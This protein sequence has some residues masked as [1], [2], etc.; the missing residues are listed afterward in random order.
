MSNTAELDLMDIKQA[1]EWASRYLGKN[2]T[3]S[4]ITYLLQYGRIKKIGN[5]GNTVINKK[6]LINYYKSFNGKREINWKNQLGS[7]L[8]WALS[9]DNVKEAETTK[10]VHRLHPYKG[11]FIPQLV[12]Y[13][14]DSHKDNFKKE[15]YFKKGDIM[16][17]PFCGSG[18]AL[19]QAN[20]LGMHAIGIDISVFNSLISNIKIDSYD[21]I[22]L[23]NELK[24]ITCKLKNFLADSETVKFE[25]ALLVELAKFNNKFFPAPEFRYK[26]SR[27]QINEYKY[28][29]EKEKEFLPIFLRLVKDYKIQLKQDKS[30]TFLDKWYLQHIRNEINFVAGLLKQ[31]KNQKIKGLVSVIL[32]RTIR[33]CRATTHSDLATLKEPVTQTYYCSK[34][35]KICK[36]LFSILSWWE[37]YSI[38]TIE[39][40]EFFKKLRTDT[41]QICL[42]GDARAINIFEEM[43]ETDPE[44]AKILKKQKIRGI[45]SSPPYVGLID[46]HEQHAYAYDLFGLKRR[47]E[48]EIGPLSKGQ[49]NEARLSYVQ[50][51]AEVL[52]NCKKFLAEDYN[53][54]LVAN[55]KYN[56]YPQIA[57]EANMK[58]VNRHRRPVLNRTERD[59]SA[60]SE[61]I[62]HLK[63]K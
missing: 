63:E 49:G 31:I 47:D 48:L 35:G 46:Y 3:T 1:S 60:Y 23:H 40:I 22:Q 26:V 11:K 42:T 13:F 36:P 51:I 52:K 53:I 20:E 33:S 38:D 17:D 32:S 10:H 18:T 39:R 14:L 24:N 7:D 55:D 41:Y 2:V 37:R 27:G 43:D 19:V 12:E 6:E 44:F 50:S 30:A 21:D 25:N 54:L 58:I 16:L 29:I 8:N 28:G 9:F 4:N 57:E 56:I 61:S 5:N 45:F 15:V 62:F 59:K 34:H